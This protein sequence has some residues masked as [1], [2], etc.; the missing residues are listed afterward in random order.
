MWKV[1]YELPC[2]NVRIGR[3][4]DMIDK[5]WIDTHR[6]RKRFKVTDIHTHNWGTIP[7]YCSREYVSAINIYDPPSPEGGYH[8]SIFK[9]ICNKCRYRNVKI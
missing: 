3:T 1:S 8:P 9:N 4:I 7:G 2:M 6:G 5:Y